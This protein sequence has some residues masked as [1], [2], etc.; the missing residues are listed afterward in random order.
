MFM[1]TYFTHTL[2][3]IA[4]SKGPQWKRKPP[5][6]SFPLRHCALVFN[7]LLTASSHALINWP[8]KMTTSTMECLWRSNCGF[9]V[10]PK[11]ESVYLSLCSWRI[12]KTRQT[13]PSASWRA[14][15]KACPPNM[16]NLD[17][18]KCLMSFQ[19]D[20]WAFPPETV[21]SWVCVHMDVS[22]HSNYCLCLY[23][24]PL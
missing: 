6:L 18:T 8:F 12:A 16:E 22:V 21:L 15:M 3:L 11:R 9:R 5:L 7:V 20:N 1:S 17:F 24:F 13:Q 2:L 4:W 10:K 19:T 23:N 14:G